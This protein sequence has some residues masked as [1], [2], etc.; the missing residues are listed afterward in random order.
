MCFQELWSSGEVVNMRKF[1]VLEW[2]GGGGRME[3]DA[4]EPP[5][6][7]PG[8]YSPPPREVTFLLFNERIF[9]LIS[10]EDVNHAGDTFLEISRYRLVPPPP[11]LKSAGG[12]QS[13]TATR[14]F[15]YLTGRGASFNVQTSG[16]LIFI[17]N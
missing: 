16:T 2:R 10:S 1:G 3:R 6:V 15:N 12:V 14:P 8:C 7:D 4:A 17:I 11:S 13:Q 9:N 5:R